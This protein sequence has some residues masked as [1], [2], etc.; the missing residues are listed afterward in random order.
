MKGIFPIEKFRRMETPFYYYDAELLRTT[1]R[2]IRQEGSMSVAYV[3]SAEGVR[4]TW[5]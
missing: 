4:L 3:V 2:T 5:L 1:L